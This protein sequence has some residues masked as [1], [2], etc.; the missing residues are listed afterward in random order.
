MT[1]KLR[2]ATL[3]VGVLLFVD[4]FLD[5]STTNVLMGG[6]AVHT[7]GSGWQ[8]F[9]IVAGVA[10]VAFVLLEALDL[11]RPAVV[12]PLLALVTLGFTVGAFADAGRASVAM[13]MIDVTVNGRQWPAW[14]GL[15]LAIALAAL[16]LGGLALERVHHG[17]PV[18]LGA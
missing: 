3:A 7:G 4:L 2:A 5:W 9:G 14:V 18:A 11:V 12:S 13:P 6:L 1:Q 10:V 17:R 15:A 8:G 16:V